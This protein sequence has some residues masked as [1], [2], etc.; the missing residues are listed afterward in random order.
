MSA[1]HAVYEAAP[2]VVWQ[3]GTK[4]PATIASQRI[5]I[6]RTRLDEF[7]WPILLDILSGEEKQ[8]AQRFHFEKDRR[9]FTCARAFMR[10]I[11]AKYLGIKAEEVCFDYSEHGK[12]E[13][14]GEA[15]PLCFNLS[16]S[17]EYALLALSRERR[18]GVDVE[19]HRCLSSIEALT[20]RFFSRM[21]YN[22][23]MQAGMEERA[24]AFYFFWTCKE[25]YL[26]ATGQGLVALDSIQIALEPDLYLLGRDGALT[27][28]HLRTFTPQ[29]EY[30]A[31]VAW[32]GEEAEVAYFNYTHSLT[33]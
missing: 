6:W 27:G 22:S 23:I 21:E 13:L 11:L 32:E 7:Y 17:G 15:P 28:W 2:S 18:I 4:A 31:A 29:D 1:R 9:R 19:Q 26:K 16:H 24:A 3:D 8:R 20:K 5:H 12:P 25:A 14:R 10:R 30:S 33:T